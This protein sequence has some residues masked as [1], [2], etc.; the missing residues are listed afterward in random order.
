MF[1]DASGQTKPGAQGR[2][3][4][5]KGAPPYP[6]SADAPL[7]L[8]PP[9][10]RDDLP[11][12]PGSC[13]AAGPGLGGTHRTRAPQ[14]WA[15]GAL[16]PRSASAAPARSNGGGGGGARGP[17]GGAAPAI[18]APSAPSASSAPASSAP[19]RRAARLG[20]VRLRSDVEPARR[21][22]ERGARAGVPQGPPSAGSLRRAGGGTRPWGGSRWGGDAPGEVAWAVGKENGQEG[23]MD[24]AHPQRWRR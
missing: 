13:P 22:K 23:A 12:T 14:V 4:A 5:G 18:H 1:R 2:T 19:Q 6:A 17:G 20:A 7:A 16:E 24:R 11:R 15:S 21:T 3:A 10:L 8:E 9:S